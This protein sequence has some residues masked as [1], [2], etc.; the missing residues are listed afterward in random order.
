MTVS[1]FYSLKKEHSRVIR[2]GDEDSQLVIDIYDDGKKDKKIW[3]LKP[4]PGWKPY[5]LFEIVQP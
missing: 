3:T 2:H 4:T 5:E 1:E